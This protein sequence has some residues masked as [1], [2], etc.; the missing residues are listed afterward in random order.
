MLKR[1]LLRLVLISLGFI[2]FMVTLSG[3]AQG[4]SRH[5]YED[6]YNKYNRVTT[7]TGLKYFHKLGCYLGQDVE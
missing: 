6:K 2:L 7:Y 3:I 5:C 1:D 4:K